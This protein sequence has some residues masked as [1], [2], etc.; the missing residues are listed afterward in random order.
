MLVGDTIFRL[1]DTYVFVVL[2]QTLTSVKRILG[3]ARMASVLI[4]RGATSVDATRDTNP[5]RTNPSV[6]VGHDFPSVI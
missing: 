2:T 3:S 1:L 6:L 4:Q 5:R